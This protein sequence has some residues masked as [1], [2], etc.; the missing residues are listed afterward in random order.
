MTFEEKE[1]VHRVI[2]GK[3]YY[4]PFGVQAET[5]VGRA[6]SFLVKKRVPRQTE[7]AP[8]ASLRPE[9]GITGSGKPDTRNLGSRVN[10]QISCSPVSTN[11]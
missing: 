11:Y 8:V 7:G 1:T 5:V 4:E 3:E 9:G 6:L 2:V 10:R